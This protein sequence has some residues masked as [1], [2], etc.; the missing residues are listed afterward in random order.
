MTDRYDDMAEVH[1]Q[2]EQ[3]SLSVLGQHCTAI[4]FPDAVRW[5][6]SKTRML[7]GLSDNAEGATGETHE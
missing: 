2:A 3:F 4:A 7:L 6:G 5:G 1:T